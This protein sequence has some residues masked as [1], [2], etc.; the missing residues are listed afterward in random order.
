[1]G[2]CGFESATLARRLVDVVLKALYCSPLSGCGSESATLARRLV[3]VVLKARA[4]KTT[5]TKR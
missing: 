2:A 4:F 1:M 5:P 3:G